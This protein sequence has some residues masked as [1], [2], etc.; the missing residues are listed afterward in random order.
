MPRYAIVW[1]EKSV[2]FVTA[3]SMEEAQK[4]FEESDDA[5]DTRGL[6]YFVES[7]VEEA[8]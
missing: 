1:V 4:I 8:E 7:C 6:D 2:T 5:L 3:P